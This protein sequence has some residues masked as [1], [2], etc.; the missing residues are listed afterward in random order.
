M[1]APDRPRRS[2]RVHAAAPASPASLLERLE[3]RVHLAAFAYQSLS[4]YL[5]AAGPLH[6]LRPSGE[7]GSAETLATSIAAIG[8]VDGDGTPDILV[9]SA[10]HGHGD[11]D[12]DD[13]DD[14]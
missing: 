6:V 11:D 2:A 4:E 5:D 13:D 10:G 8:D 14:D 1:P 3:P 7:R 9:G 12:D